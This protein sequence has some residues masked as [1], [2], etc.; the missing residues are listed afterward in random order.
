MSTA[1]EKFLAVLANGPIVLADAVVILLG[2]DSEERMEVGLQLMVQQGTAL[3]NISG[4]PE[5]TPDPYTAKL[6]EL[7][8][9]MLVLSGGIEDPPRRRS[10]KTMT[11]KLL[12]RGVSPSAV[13]ADNDAMNTREQAVNF[14]A[15]ALKQGWKRAILV[16]SPYHM[17]RAFLTILKAIME[18]DAT[19]R[20]HIIPVTAAQA[21]W[22]TPPEG[23][24]ETRLELYSLEMDKIKKYRKHVAAWSDGLDYLK[25]W[26]AEMQKPVEVKDGEDN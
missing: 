21:P 17:P 15:H 19:E 10:A 25:F 1:R 20:L 13:Y 8:A 2:E 9:P 26:E 24:D 18:E 14:V 23:A 3:F 11:P 5:I 16:A 12:G 4:N 7:H 6:I 22:W